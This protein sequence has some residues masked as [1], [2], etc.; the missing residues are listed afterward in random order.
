[1]ERRGVLAHRIPFPKGIYSP[2]VDYQWLVRH[3]DLLRCS[4]Y[5]LYPNFDEFVRHYMDPHSLVMQGPGIVIRVEGYDSGHMAYVH[6]FVHSREVFSCL[7]SVKELTQVVMEYFCLHRVE[8]EIP[9]GHRGVGRLLEKVGF[10]H[11]AHLRFRGKRGTIV[12]D[13]D[14]YSI[15]R[16]D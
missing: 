3:Y 5:I 6:G 9:E 2:Y 11:D 12:Y 8:A 7:G 15:T 4:D 10:T 16:G 1:M 14:M 13:T